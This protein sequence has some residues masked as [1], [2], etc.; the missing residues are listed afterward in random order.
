MATT[1]RGVVRDGKIEILEKM[2]LPEGA[3]I[4]ITLVPDDE[5]QFWLGAS[6]STLHA[7]W[8]NPEDDVYAELLEK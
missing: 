7:I 3:K 5:S 2:D 6:R 1:V 4:L 8:D